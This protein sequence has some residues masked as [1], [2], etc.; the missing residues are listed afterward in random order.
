M[1]ALLIIDL[2]KY[3]INENTESLP[4]RIANFIEKHTFDYTIF[5]QFFNSPNSNFVKI[6]HWNHMFGPPETDI[7]EE[8]SKYLTGNN[9][10]KKHTFSI[11]R[12]EGF[13]EFIKGNVID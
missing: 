13:D 3:F 6:H 10:F 2:Q 1:K 11:F 7:A 9:L 4:G 8:L 12:A 5:F